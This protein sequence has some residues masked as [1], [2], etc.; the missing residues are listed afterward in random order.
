MFIKRTL[1]SCLALVGAA[2]ALSTASA[3]T[4]TIGTNQPGSLFYS[5]GVGISE[6]LIKED[7]S[8]RVQA[9]AGSGALMAL[10]DQ[11]T[12]DLAV[13]N[14][15]EMAQAYNGAFPSKEKHPNL[16][17][18]SRLFDSQVGF[19]VGADSPIKSL[20]D[21]EGKRV[22]ARFSAA[23]IIE[24]MRKA[25]IANAGLSDDDIDLVSV[26]N[27]IRGGDLL[28]SGRIDVAFL[29]A[30]SGTVEELNASMGGVRFL[31]LNDDEKSVKALQSVMAQGYPAVMERETL[32]AGI[33]PDTKFLT[34]GVVLVANKDMDDKHVTDIL[35]A[36]EKNTNVLES[37]VR[38]FK[39]I[40]RKRMGGAINVEYHPAAK[41]YFSGS[42]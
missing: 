5:T 28:S 39:G 36:L 42:Q 18:V 2:F 19:L 31:S 11:G 35:S 9:Y 21:V 34:Y 41:Q 20:A 33:E 23:P 3:Q 7:I 24:L 14:V 13:V 22:A 15:F 27:S 1:L 4:L 40:D 25:I 6:A 12:L 37:A 26:P 38:N 29:S 8:A 17:V 10:V 16:R 32:P 30:G